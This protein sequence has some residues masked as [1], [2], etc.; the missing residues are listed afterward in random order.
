MTEEDSFSPIE[1][2]REKVDGIYEALEGLI[3]IRRVLDTLRG[4][5]Q[6]KIFLKIEVVEPDKPWIHIAEADVDI[7][8]VLIKAAKNA[9]VATYNSTKA[10]IEA[11]FKTT[12]ISKYKGK[13]PLPY[14]EE[15]Q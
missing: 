14:V 9:L 2:E 15:A 5:K 1:N 10:S 13:G 4:K 12:F 3:R 7:D 6:N 8:P 11:D